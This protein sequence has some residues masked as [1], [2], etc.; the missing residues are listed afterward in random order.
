MNHSEIIIKNLPDFIQQDFKNFTNLMSHYYQ[1]L[2]SCEPFVTFQELRDDPEA[3]I[4][5]TLSEFGFYFNQKFKVSKRF[6]LRT[7]REFFLCRGTEASFRFLFKALFGTS[8]E[9]RYPRDSMMVCSDAIY[10]G[11]HYIWVRINYQTQSDHE[12]QQLRQDAENFISVQAT[13]KTSGFSVGVEK[14]SESFVRGNLYLVV[15]IAASKTEF[16]FPEEI[17]IHSPNHNAY[18]T[19]SQIIAF[20]IQNQGVLYKVGDRIEITDTEGSGYPEGQA[21]VKSISTGGINDLIIPERGTDYKVGDKIKAHTYEQSADLGSGFV[22]VVTEVSDLGE[23]MNL[24]I[25]SAGFGYYRIPNSEEFYTSSHSGVGARFI[26]VTT[27]IGRITEIRTEFPYMND[28]ESGKEVRIHSDQGRGAILV[29]DSRSAFDSSLNHKTTKG[30]LEVNGIITDSHKVQQF[31]Y[32]LRSPI[33][34]THYRTIVNSLLHPPGFIRDDVQ[35]IEVLMS[36][37]LKTNQALPVETRPYVRS[38]S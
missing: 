35:M 7:I 14:I 12:Y 38:V 18:G 19:L 34:S 30:F 23:I 22:A 9:I 16:L 36:R 8:C 10:S 37:L 4:D 33:D 20:G 28:S 5:M 25:F 17:R 24:E 26:G 31:S 11:N 29:L 27:S 2:E 13:G 32:E 6:L 1:N 15:Q 21:W 3:L